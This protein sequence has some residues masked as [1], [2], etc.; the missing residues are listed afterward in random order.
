MKTAKR[1]FSSPLALWSFTAV[2]ILAASAVPQHA[3]ALEF[4]DIAQEGQ[5]RFLEAHPE[6]HTYRYESRVRISEESLITG[7]VTLNTCHFE[8]DPIRK[9]VIA[10][11]PN[12]LQKLEITQA[13]GVGSLEV[14]GH[15][16]EMTDV[17]RGA[18][19]C[20][21]LESKALERLNETTYRLNA[22][23]LMRRYFDGYLPMR[24]TLMLSWPG[25]RITLKE[26][27]PAPQKGVTLLQFPG[28]AEMDII[29]A[30]RL[31]ANIDLTVKP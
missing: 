28:R 1:R 14:R 20:I 21:D 29:F 26:T 7:V 13:S 3:R 2:L 31:T 8:L 27:N 25:D 23:P 6:P 11:N 24:A 18:S 17:K 19:V 15:L 10:F 22:G 30:G 4:S 12:R 16:I 5:L 9:V